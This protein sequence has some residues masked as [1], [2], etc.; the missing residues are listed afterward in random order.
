MLAPCRRGLCALI[1]LYNEDMENKN[2]VET[3]KAESGVDTTLPTTI[4]EAKKPSKL[5]IL[6]VVAGV[7]VLLA[8]AIVIIGRK[9]VA[10]PTTNDNSDSGQVADNVY[11]N[12]EFYYQLTLPPKWSAVSVSANDKASAMFMT[13]SDAMMSVDAIKQQG[14]LESFL[15]L[16]DE[17]GGIVVKKSSPIK[18][19]GYDGV[20]REESWLTQGVEVLTAY[21]KIQDMIYTFYLLPTGN[22]NSVTNETLLR[23]YRSVLSSF[24]L[25]DT[26][27]LG[28]DWVS[29]AG[30]NWQMQYPQNWKLLEQ[31]KDGKKGLK[32]YRDN[33]EITI[34]Q[35]SVESMVC[36]FADS[37]AVEGYAGDLRDK[38][39]VEIATKE[40]MLLR[41]YFKSNQG[42]KTSL[43]FCGKGSDATQ[44]VSP[45]FYGTIAYTVPAKYDEQIVKEM[46]SIIKTIEGTRSE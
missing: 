18:V 1:L 15:G 2:K 44:Y 30:W 43:Y 28:K 3:I 26:T 4:V 39:Y 36:Q 17:D 16:S 29:Y 41:R 22:K 34:N 6:G 38:D 33:Y 5:W 32:L 37:E 45:T 8:L 31:N 25:T 42:D 46:D 40:N 35:A 27:N 21:V 20:E 9:D 19:G 12:K 7:L 10:Q 11:Q 14:S 23:E 13:S 24:R